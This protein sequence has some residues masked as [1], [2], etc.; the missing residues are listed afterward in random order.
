MPSLR[1]DFDYLLVHFVA[2]VQLEECKPGKFE[3]SDSN[4]DSDFCGCLLEAG[5]LI[6]NQDCE[7]SNLFVRVFANVAQVG[8]ALL[9]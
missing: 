4:S 9:S 6:C 2:I 5:N 1:R 7:S 8:S 3:V